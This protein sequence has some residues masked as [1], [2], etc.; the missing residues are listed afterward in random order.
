M[1][2]STSRYWAGGFVASPVI[3]YQIWLFSWR[4]GV[5]P[6]E[7][8]GGPFVVLTCAFFVGG[9]VFGLKV[10]FP[11]LPSSSSHRRGLHAG[12]KIDDYLDILSKTLIGM[13]I[14]FETPIVIF[15]LARIGGRDREVAA[16]EVRLCSPRHLSSSPPSSPR[17]RTS[18]HSAPSRSR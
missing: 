7:E 2:Q 3:L 10:A 1:L 18:R 12:L 11:W 6:R 14:C 5:P 15:F 17:P 8:V 16:A 4:P 9:G 13:G